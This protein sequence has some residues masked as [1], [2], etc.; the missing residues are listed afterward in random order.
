MRQQSCHLDEPG[1]EHIPRKTN[2]ST[3]RAS[4]SEHEFLPDIR[5][6]GILVLLPV[7]SLL[8]CSSPLVRPCPFDQSWFKRD[9]T[10]A[11]SMAAESIPTELASAKS[12]TE[13]LPV[14][15]SSIERDDTDRD[16]IDRDDTDRDDIEQGTERDD[17]ARCERE[18][19]D[20]DTDDTE[21]D[22]KHAARDDSD[23]VKILE[24]TVEN[25]LALLSTLLTSS[26]LPSFNPDRPN[27]SDLTPLLLSHPPSS[28]ILLFQKHAFRVPVSERPDGLH[29]SPLGAAL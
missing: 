2:A 13:D 8:R 14:W 15:A 4:T 24:L 19:D 18:S 21:P 1:D 22:D 10:V 28:G 7:S 6:S 12:N 17:R 27:S 3:G 29:R 23:C 11:A 25:A 5:V 9:A 16:D 20:R 26:T